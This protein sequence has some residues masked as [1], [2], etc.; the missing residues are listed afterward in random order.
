M[1]KIKIAVMVLLLGTMALAAPRDGGI[2]KELNLTPE[3]TKQLENNRKESLK[4]MKDYQEKTRKEYETLFGELSKDNPNK[5][6]VALSKKNILDLE[7]KRLDSMIDNASGLK[8]VLTKEQF[9]TF[10]KKQKNRGKTDRTDKAEKKAHT[11][12]KD[13]TAK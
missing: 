1:K 11:H 2:F 8:K 7:S 5:S 12:T 6:T 3:Q 13:T 4:V 10:Q 9:A